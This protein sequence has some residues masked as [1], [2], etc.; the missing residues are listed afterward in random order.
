MP[1]LALGLNHTTAPVAI[2]ERVVFA[3]ED[4]PAAL[5]ELRD[6][7]Q[8]TAAA[9]LSTCNRT[10]LYCEL[11]H[12]DDRAVAEWFRRYHGFAGQQLN[13]H[14]YSHH[15]D[16]AV[17]H[18]MRVAS[19]LDSLVLGEP[20][21][22]GQIKSAYQVARESGTVGTILERLFQSS[23]SVAKQVRTDT[24]IGSSPVSVAFA[25]VSL[26]KQIFGS[27]TEHTALL[28]GAGETIEL[29]A[30]HLHRNGL[31]RMVIANRTEARAR[32]LAAEFDAHAVGLEKIPAYL[33]QA[34]IIISST[35][36]PG[37]IVSFDDVRGA[38]EARKHRPIFIA[39]I[40]VPLD[41]DPAVGELEDIYLYNV[42]D[43][44]GVIQDNLNSR[45]E[46]AL[47]A[48]GI[49]EAQ[50]SDFMRWL[51]TRGVTPTIR[52]VRS[53]AERTRDELLAKAEDMLARGQSPQQALRFVANT[54]TNKL[55]HSPTVELR[56]A[57][58]DSRVDIIDAARLLFQLDEDL[59]TG[60]TDTATKDEE[61][62]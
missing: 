41:V 29:A 46:A 49:I 1:L 8:V 26:A 13:S 59:D 55:L 36:S 52:A 25:A 11:R 42:D 48:E 56:R 15:G 21:I 34:D 50:V 23:F 3:P 24:A 5:L 7:E 2:R 30:R 18:M 4:V 19:G 16:G 44:E 12:G 6:G 47:Q 62:S 14:I 31:Q 40:A 10:D 58:A 33:R 54:L 35:G 43:L 32:R 27:L 53:T 37:V 61:V 22:L 45:R 51:G 39:D 17:R 57:G 28:I 38:I 9:I 60:A 20:Q